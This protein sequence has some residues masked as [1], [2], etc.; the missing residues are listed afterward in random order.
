MGIKSSSDKL[1]N[2]SKANKEHSDSL[3]HRIQIIEKDY[4]VSNNRLSELKD[5]IQILKT[6]IEQSEKVKQKKKVKPQLSRER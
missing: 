6:L 2:L 5:S 1:K 3:I 4:N